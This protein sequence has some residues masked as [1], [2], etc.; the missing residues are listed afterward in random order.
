MSVLFLVVDQSFF[1]GRSGDIL[2]ASSEVGILEIQ[3]PSS[4]PNFLPF[5]NKADASLYLH[6]V[7]SSFNGNDILDFSIADLIA[8]LI[9]STPLSSSTDRSSF[10]QIDL[11]KRPK[12]NLLIAIDAVDTEFES[13]AQGKKIQ[14]TP[15]SVPKDSLAA[16]TT[17]STGATPAAHGIV[18]RTWMNDAGLKERAFVDAAQPALVSFADI[19][20]QT[21]R[22]IP[23]TVS[24]SADY[25]MAAA[26]TAHMTT[27]KNKPTANNFAYYYNQRTAAVDSI[28]FFGRLEKEFFLTK[29][30][31]MQLIP[32]LSEG[33]SIKEQ[34]ITVKIGSTS[35]TFNLAEEEDFLFFAELVMIYNFGSHLKTNSF[36]A[37]LAADRFPDSFAVAVSS[38][39]SIKA[40]SSQQYVA[41]ARLADNILSSFIT[42][43]EEAYGNEGVV[44]V[45]FLGTSISPLSSEVI[46]TTTILLEHD[47]VSEKLDEELLPSVHFKPYLPLI[48][49]NTH[50]VALARALTDFPVRV[51][52]PERAT[53]FA[54][55]LLADYC[56]DDPCPPEGTDSD[57]ASTPDPDSDSDSDSASA[58]AS[59]SASSSTAASASGSESGSANFNN[60]G[61]YVNLTADELTYFQ[62]IFLMIFVLLAAVIAAIIAVC[63]ISTGGDTIIT[64]TAPKK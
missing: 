32:K 8:H 12:A 4:F 42:S 54:R 47:L 41:A 46:S 9:G 44:E 58:S 29:A 31:I 22:G 52:C 33:I 17:I 51:Y 19:L 1:Q 6:N 62:V 13:L 43:F 23:L 18:G 53:R 55:G 26:L 15:T 11:F 30:I 5:Q 60:T 2:I 49:R 35:A 59:A 25:Q 24:I 14:I 10:P 64:V 7:A 56:Y 20:S 16:L 21:F 50:C 39:K 61:Y 57:S 27:F 37:S 34:I 45:V 63:T 28:T 3:T 40:K 36:F 38:L 48:Q